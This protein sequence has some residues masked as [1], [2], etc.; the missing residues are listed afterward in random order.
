[1]EDASKYEKPFEYVKQH[2]KPM[3]DNVRR[4]N[5]R[6]KWWLFGEARPGMRRALSG[7]S[8]YIATPWVSKH[9]LFIW[10]PIETIPSLVVVIARD[11]DYFL[12]VLHSKFTL[13]GL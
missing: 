3:R 8:R 2:V 9:R 4:K 13:F 11:D 5:H 12:G 1:M 7:L 6:E 10:I